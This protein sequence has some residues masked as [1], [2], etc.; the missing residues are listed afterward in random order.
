MMPI[1][2]QDA[3]FDAE[4]FRR[5]VQQGNDP[6][7]PVR[8]TLSRL[9]DRWTPLLLQVLQVGVMRYSQL[10]KAINSMADAPVSQ[11]ILTQKLRASERDG[12]IQ[13]TVIPS[14]PPQV[15]YALTPMGQQMVQQLAQLVGWLEQHQQQIDLARKN[16]DAQLASPS[17]PQG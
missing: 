11:R 16:Y 15:E 14:V 1:T 3:T 8:E 9:G 10:H 12:F 2:Q 13:R 17:E 6:H 4:E 7:G 5:R